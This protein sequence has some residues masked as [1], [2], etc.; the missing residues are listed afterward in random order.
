MCN[1]CCSANPPKTCSTLRVAC[2]CFNN[3]CTCPEDYT[4]VCGTDGR[5]YS[6]ECKARCEKQ[7][8]HRL[9]TH[10]QSWFTD[11]A[12][13]F[14]ASRARVNVHA[15]QDRLQDSTLVT[16]AVVLKLL[17]PTLTYFK[18]SALPWGLIA[19][20]VKQ[21]LPLYYSHSL[22][23]LVHHGL[24]SPDLIKEPPFRVHDNELISYGS[25]VRYLIYL[26]FKNNVFLNILLLM[27]QPQQRKRVTVSGIPR[28]LVNHVTRDSMENGKKSADFTSNLVG[29]LI[30][31]LNTTPVDQEIWES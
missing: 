2:N 4:P 5:T 26:K 9:S 28:W 27:A 14:R 23:N 17:P 13:N 10:N 18:P 22:S 24:M 1:L 31:K 15:T 8:R 12:N 30:L 11:C 20:I 3:Q 16:A 19:S 6:N 25:S 21:I 29:W 7:V